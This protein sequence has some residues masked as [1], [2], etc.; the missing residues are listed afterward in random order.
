MQE[1]ITIHEKFLEE[2]QTVTPDGMLTYGESKF[3]LK[4]RNVKAMQ[5]VSIIFIAT[6]WSFQLKKILKVLPA[7]AGGS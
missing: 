3:A 5:V 2:Y 4:Y 6:E 1:V 7:L